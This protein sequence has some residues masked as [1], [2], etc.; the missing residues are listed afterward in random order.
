[1]F[2]RRFAATVRAHAHVDRI[3]EGAGLEPVRRELER[4]GV[5][6]GRLGLEL[7]VI[8]AAMFQKLTAEFPRFDLVDVSAL[9]LGQRMIKDAEELAA[10]RSAVALYDAVHQTMAAHVR[11]GVA[12]HEL[13]GEVQRALRRAGHA[14][15]VAQRRWDAALQPEG[16]LA[17]G[18]H[19]TAM[20][21]GPITI[22]GVGLSRA[23]PFG[24]SSRRL[25]TGDLV[26]I[27]LGL[28]FDGYHA[29]MARTYAVGDAPDALLA[30]TVAVRRC[31]DAV[32]AAIK[33]LATGAELYAT[34]V[35]V[36][37][38][39]GVEHAFQGHS[40]THGPYVGH[41]LG[42]ELDEPPVLGPTAAAT[43]EEGMVLAVEIKL[44]SPGFGAV[45][46]E[47]DVVVTEDGCVVLGDIPRTT[48]VVDRSGSMGPLPARRRRGASVTA[49][50][51]R[52]RRG[53]I[54]R[55]LAAVAGLALQEPATELLCEA[56]A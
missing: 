45:N 12:E 16:A 24:A 20:S 49:V 22:T 10:M 9:L 53:D 15:L 52:I 6:G 33:P 44:V 47:D 26:N 30:W 8:P 37:H 38:A 35:A 3:K 17:S 14:G 43:I 23:V 18:P 1:M 13:A 7:D 54:R 28:N 36:A 41:G 19:L 42:L 25:V 2:A 4:L 32:L 27:D 56:Q 48:F 46:L 5:R 39:L 31:Q 51:G 34:G 55:D 50:A 40:G 21:G 11:P 29:D